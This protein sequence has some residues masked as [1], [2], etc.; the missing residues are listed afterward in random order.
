M[1]P[2]KFML[3]YYGTTLKGDIVMGNVPMDCDG[4][5]SMRSFQIARQQIAEELTRVRKIAC[6][7]ESI[8]IT[9]CIPIDE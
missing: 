2:R 5:L 7:S 8:T 4:K 3:A 1:I 6:D 9:A